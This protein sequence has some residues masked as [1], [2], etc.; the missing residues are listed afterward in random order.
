MKNQL[1]ANEQ[2]GGVQNQRPSTTNMISQKKVQLGLC[3]A[4][5]EE[6]SS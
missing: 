2:D 6:V 5:E 1:G 4:G 3:N